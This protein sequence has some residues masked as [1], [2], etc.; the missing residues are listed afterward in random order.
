MLAAG[1]SERQAYDQRTF[2]AVPAPQRSF[3]AVPTGPSEQDVDQAAS[4]VFGAVRKIPPSM[5]QHAQRAQEAAMQYRQQALTA[6]RRGDIAGAEA[7]L[8]SLRNLAR[9]T[10]QTWT[11]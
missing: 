9:E 2:T 8:R 7:N 10:E 11:R 3:T 5:G 6:L 1:P 4:L